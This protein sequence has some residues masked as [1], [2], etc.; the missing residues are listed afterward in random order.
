M[1]LTFKDDYFQLRFFY[2]ATCVFLKQGIIVNLALQ[3]FNKGS[4]EITMS[5]PL[6]H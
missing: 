6:S 3:S 5:V 2:K 1:F 4:I